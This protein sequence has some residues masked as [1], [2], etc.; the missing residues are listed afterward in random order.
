MGKAQQ[1]E[2]PKVVINDRFTVRV[3]AGPATRGMTLNVAGESL[4]L[5]EDAELGGLLVTSDPSYNI[6]R[7]DSLAQVS[8]STGEFQIIYGAKSNFLFLFDV[9][10]EGKFIEKTE[11]IRQR[12]ESSERERIKQ[13]DRLSTEQWFSRWTVG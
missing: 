4:T 13:Q 11:Q 5:P 1:E 9:F 6:V 12:N 8:T 7:G 3:L 2:T 10:G